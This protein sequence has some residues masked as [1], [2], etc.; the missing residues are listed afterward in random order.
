MGQSGVKR[1]NFRWSRA[2]EGSSPR[3]KQDRYW[4]GFHKGGTGM[5]KGKLSPP[6]LLSLLTMAFN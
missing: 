3:H 4:K 5:E 2:G 6:P 1:S